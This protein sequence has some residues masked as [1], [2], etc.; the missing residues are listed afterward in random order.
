MNILQL[1]CWTPD[2]SPGLSEGGLWCSPMYV[3][4]PFPFLKGKMVCPSSSCGGA[5]SAQGVYKPT[6]PIPLS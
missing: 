5:G 4:P 6:V 3:A 2:I 1:T